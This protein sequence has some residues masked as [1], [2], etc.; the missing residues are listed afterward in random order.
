MAKPGRAEGV[1]I[2]VVLADDHPEVREEIQNLLSSEFDVL[3]AVSEGNA[4]MT[5]VADLKPD[6]VISDVQMPQMDGIEAGSRLVS[7]GLCQAVV[8]LSMYP[9]AHLVLT[10][11]RAGIRAYVLK[12]DAGEELIP[13]IYAALR[14]ERY[15]SR[16]IRDKSS[17]TLRNF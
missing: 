14:G 16:G 5:A 6:A 1:R 4:L 11:F 13:A 8:L 15:L 17:D 2:R 10:A 7:R 12:L 3:C 9:D